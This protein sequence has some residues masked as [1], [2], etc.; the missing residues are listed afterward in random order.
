MVIST[1]ELCL[2][3]F[4]FLSLAS[5]HAQGLQL[6]LPSLRHRDIT[7]YFDACSGRQGAFPV[8]E[9][10]KSTQS[11]RNGKKLLEMYARYNTALM[12]VALAES[13]VWG[14]GTYRR[15]PGSINC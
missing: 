4:V 13:T 12:S 2:D 11:E 3:F 10:A 7:F 1:F 5:E 9:E 8:Q 14:F 15:K 6:S